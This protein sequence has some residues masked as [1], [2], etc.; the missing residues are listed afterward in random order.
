MKRTIRE[1]ILN[2]KPN[3]KVAA[4]IEFGIDLTL[5]IRLI[6]LT[7]Q[8]RLQELQSTMRSFDMLREEAKKSRMKLYGRA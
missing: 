8:E 3:S 2:P 5:L 7:P 4:A 1:R 6:D